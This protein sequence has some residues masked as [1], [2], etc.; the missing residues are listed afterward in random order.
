MGA[1]RAA[2]LHVFGMRG[3]GR[4]FENYAGMLWEDDDE[5]AVAHLPAEEGY[6]NLSVAMANLRYGL[7]LATREGLMNATQHDALIALVKLLH[8]PERGWEAVWQA[9]GKVGLGGRELA[10]LRTFIAESKPDLKRE[11]ALAVL[12]AMREHQAGPAAPPPPSFR[13]EPTIFWEHLCS[14]FGPIVEARPRAINRAINREQLVHHIRLSPLDRE[15]LRH[16]ALLHVLVGQEIRRS[17]IAAG[18]D[19]PV[20]ERFRRKRGLAGER[21]LSAWMTE[22]QVDRSGTR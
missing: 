22:Q 12:D 8:Y 20:L 13:F 19:R 7:E 21:A 18:D 15:A 5:V 1:L 10:A 16:R 9:A 14:H 6:R 17:G 3:V 2:E 11:D 4:I